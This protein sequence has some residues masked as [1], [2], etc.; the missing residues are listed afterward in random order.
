MPTSRVSGPGFRPK[1]VFLGPGTRHDP[2][3]GITRSRTRSARS[4][5]ARRTGCSPAQSARAAAPRP[6]RAC[7]PLQNSM[8]SILHAGWPTPSINFRPAPTAGSTRCYRSQTLHSP[9]FQR[10]VGRLDAY[11]ARAIG[12]GGSGCIRRHIAAADAA[13][14]C[15]TVACRAGKKPGSREFGA[16]QAARMTARPVHLRCHFMPT[17]ATLC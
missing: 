3:V 9:K 1:V 12:F 13:T 16:S 14:P 6:S 15:A 17:V 8:D 2:R 5:S 11:A 10:K 7:S 4:P